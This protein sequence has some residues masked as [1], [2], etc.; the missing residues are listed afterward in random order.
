MVAL[1]IRSADFLRKDFFFTLV[2]L[3]PNEHKTLFPST[4]CLLRA[5]VF[6]PG[7]PGRVL[8]SVGDMSLPARRPFS[9]FSWLDLSRV[10][11]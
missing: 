9:F 3:E 10:S 4:C 6:C 8:D 11:S 2:P 7:I 5:V 1:I